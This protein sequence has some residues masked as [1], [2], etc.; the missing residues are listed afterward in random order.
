MLIFA[1]FAWI[2]LGLPL[3][4]VFV[5]L[6]L[7]SHQWWQWPCAALWLAPLGYE[8]LIQYHCTGECNIR[9][10]ILFVWPLEILLLTTLSGICAWTYSR[11]G[12]H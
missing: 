1:Y 7:R 2:L 11:R 5:V 3:F 6:G 4:L 10:D 12:T 8:T 9:I